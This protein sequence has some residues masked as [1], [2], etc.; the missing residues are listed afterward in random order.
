MENY[1]EL[2]FQDAV[3][4]LQRANG[5]YDKYQTA[6]KHRTQDTLSPD[7][8]A[9]IQQRD[10]FYIASVNADGWP[11]IQHRGGARGFLKVVNPTRLAC[12][13]YHGNRQFVTMDNLKAEARVSLFLMDYMNHSRLKIQG[14]ATLVPVDQADPALVAGL[15]TQ[16]APA[17]R[18][19]V[20]D[21]V[22]M[23]WNCPKYIPTL[24]PEDAIRQIIGPQIGQ[25]QAE[26]EA[27]KAELEALRKADD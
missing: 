10:S 24:Y 19:L 7:D 12:A 2:M 22:A 21:V 9:Y 1:A 6:Y 13:D 20:I 8:V 15:D 27:L 17:E 14:R 16:A 11:Y 26:N 18:V 4:D 5:S 3:A 25:L 23:D